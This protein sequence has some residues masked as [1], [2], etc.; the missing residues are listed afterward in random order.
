[1]STEQAP[2]S[3]VGRDEGSGRLGPLNGHGLDLD[4]EERRQKRD[5]GGS[6]V[7]TIVI[8]VLVAITAAVFYI[9]HARAVDR[10]QPPVIRPSEATIGQGVQPAS[11]TNSATAGA[12]TT[13][14]AGTAGTPAAGTS[15]TGTSATGTPAAGTVTAPVPGKPAT[16]PAT[17]TAAPAK[18]GKEVKDPKAGKEV[19]EPAKTGD[20]EPKKR[21]HHKAEDSDEAPHALPRLPLPP[22][23]E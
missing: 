9:L 2:D 23:T 15:A 14:P 19:T 3:R 4:A 11:A 17:G 16:P 21:K 5:K 13:N 10:N 7:V 1:M 8:V 12:P 20:G 22:P 6:Q 18:D